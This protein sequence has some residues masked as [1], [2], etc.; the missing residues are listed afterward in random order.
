MARIQTGPRD[1]SYDGNHESDPDVSHVLLGS[2]SHGSV[3][4][5][6]A[7]DRDS[8]DGRSQWVWLTFPNGDLALA[9]FPQGSTYESVTQFGPE[10]GGGIVEFNRDALD[11][12]ITGNYGE[13]QFRDERDE[14]EPTMKRPSELAD[15]A[16]I[17][18]EE[19]LSTSDG[20]G[21]AICRHC[22]RDIVR[23]AGTWIDPEATGD[24]SIWR[25]T[26]DAHDTF[27]ADHEPE[28]EDERDHR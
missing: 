15:E 2:A 26:C 11:R 13:D 24:D 21:T 8:D 3:A 5:V 1:L 7:A 23:V 17:T 4:L 28:S 12:H 10:F 19:F 25:E 14:E 27:V 6:L 16:G 20:R 9:T 22:E 18:L